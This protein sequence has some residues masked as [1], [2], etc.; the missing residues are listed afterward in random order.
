MTVYGGYKSARLRNKL[1]KC[2]QTPSYNIRCKVATPAGST[3]YS[4]LRQAHPAYGP[5]VI[6][7]YVVLRYAP[8]D[9]YLI[10]H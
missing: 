2:T 4:A 8:T 9:D 3:V 1:A 5:D 7:Y 10:C 6:E